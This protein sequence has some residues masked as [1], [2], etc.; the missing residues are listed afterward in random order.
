MG[1][2]NSNSSFIYIFS[3]GRG[4]AAFIRTPLNQAFIIDMAAEGGTDGFSPAKFIKDNLIPRI[5]KYKGKNIAQAVLSHPHADHITECEE[6]LSGNP[7]E[8][9]L[10]TCPHDKEPPLFAASEKLNW[11]RIKNP[12]YARNSEGKY[13][14]L[15]NS[16]QLPLQTICFDSPR[17][18]PPNIEYGLYYMRPPVVEKLHSS[19]DNKYGNATSLVFLYRH[20]PHTI[21]IPGDITPEALEMLLNQSEGAEKR[22]TRFDRSF[23]ADHPNWHKECVDQP[24]LAGFLREQG[25]AILVAPHHGLESCYCGSLYKTMKNGKPRLNVISER[26]KCKET[27]GKVHPFYQSADGASGLDIVCEG[28]LEK[29]R[30]SVTTVNGHHI[31]IVFDG[32]GAPKVY[33][34][35]DALKLI[36]IA[37]GAA[38]AKAR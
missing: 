16:R 20:G 6:L 5:D 37:D 1:W 28:T 27:D 30:R 14:E 25:L 18:V 9:Q 24:S 21:L 31:L 19:D 4:N 32:A 35:K 10:I 8:P 3:V 34:E 38:A 11:A 33:M 15:Y 12:D 23:T 7:L 13:R 2:E 29:E 22:F 26:R 36:R 17:A